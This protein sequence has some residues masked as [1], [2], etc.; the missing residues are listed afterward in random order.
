MELFWP[1]VG[2]NRPAVAGCP[3]TYPFFNLIETE[4]TQ[5][6]TNIQV[7]VHRSAIRHLL[8]FFDSLNLS[9]RDLRLGGNAR[10]RI[11]VRNK[12]LD[13]QPASTLDAGYFLDENF[14]CDFDIGIG[15]A[16]EFWPIINYKGV[17]QRP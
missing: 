4:P 13:R 5:T 14:I 7:T 3:R 17:G 10:H 1:A 11:P 16:A 9:G 6:T 15:R 2:F 12:L 8:A